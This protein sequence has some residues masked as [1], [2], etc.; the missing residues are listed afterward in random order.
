MN[1]LELKRQKNKDFG[2]IDPD[3]LHQVTIE[4]PV[5]NKDTP[6]D[7]LRYFKQHRDKKTILWAYNFK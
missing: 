3:K 7:L 5:C 4:N 1:M 2:F 6:G